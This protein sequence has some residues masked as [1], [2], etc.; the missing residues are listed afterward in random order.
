MSWV[1]FNMVGL[2]GAGV[3]LVLLTFFKSVMGLNYLLATVAAVETTVIHNFVWHERWTW[4]HRMLDVKRVFSRLLRFNAGNGLVSIAGNVV[5][6]WLFVSKLHFNYLI[7]NVIAIG[8]C[9]IANFLISDRL[10]FKVHT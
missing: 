4:A 7:A 5:V 6:M 10:V 2:V 8:T 1:K 3:Q 9:A